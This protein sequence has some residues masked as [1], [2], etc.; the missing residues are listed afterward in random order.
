VNE[1]FSSRVEKSTKRKVTL[2]VAFLFGFYSKWLS[3]GAGQK[4]FE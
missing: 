1:A 3:A 4:L 2:P